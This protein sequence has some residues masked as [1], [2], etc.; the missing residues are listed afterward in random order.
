MPAAPSSG[1]AVGAVAVVVAMSLTQD[2]GCSPPLSSV[3]WSSGWASN[4]GGVTVGL[5]VGADVVRAVERSLVAR[6]WGT[7]NCDMCALESPEFKGA[8]TPCPCLVSG[9]SSSGSRAASLRLSTASLSR[10][11]RPGEAG[12]VV[13]IAGVVVVGVLMVALTGV[14][15]ATSQGAGLSPALRCPLAS[16]GR[17]AG[18]ASADCRVFM[19]LTLLRVAPGGGSPGSGGVS[20]G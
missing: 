17:G 5:G 15:G 18:D 8:S 2:A 16:P 10:W 7:S 9:H 11:V 6:G 13:V 19:E 4:V 20:L 14:A 1:G 12:L 3:L